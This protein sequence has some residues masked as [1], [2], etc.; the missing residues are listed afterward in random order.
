MT[1]SLNGSSPARPASTA[2]RKLLAR[3]L[4]GFGL[5]FFTPLAAFAAPVAVLEF[6]LNDLTLNPDVAA[7][8]ERAASLR[9]LLIERLTEHHGIEV[10]DNPPRAAIEAEKGRGYLF[11]RPELAAEIGRE[12]G[13][14]WIVSGRLHKPTFLFAYMKAQ[15]IDTRTGR[16]A[17]DF[18]VEVK[19]QQKKITPRGIE[20]LARQISDA[21]AALAKQS[22]GG[23]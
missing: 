5:I 16:V 21:L 9:P 2:R 6:E 17:A 14:A 3:L 7:E 20:T 15:L 1:R 22:D 11:D 4:T 10:I 12:A 13:A 23:S 19:G 8:T 18:V